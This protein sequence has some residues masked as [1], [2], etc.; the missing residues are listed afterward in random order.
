VQFH[1]ARVLLFSAI[2]SLASVIVTVA[3]ALADNGAG[4]IPR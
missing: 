4:P 3:T 1:R 2:L